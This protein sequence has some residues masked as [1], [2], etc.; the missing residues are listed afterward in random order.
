MPLKSV[1]LSG[2]DFGGFVSGAQPGT[3]TITPQ[4]ERSG[5]GGVILI[6]SKQGRPGL[7]QVTGILDAPYSLRALS[8]AQMKP[9][10]LTDSG[11]LTAG[12]VTVPIG[13]TLTVPAN[14][15]NTAFV[16]PPLSISVNY[17]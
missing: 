13:G 9:I 1:L 11:V 10:F 7:I 8:S 6:K 3:V 17:Q 16:P 14:A 5:T 2:I 15:R 4:G 12:S